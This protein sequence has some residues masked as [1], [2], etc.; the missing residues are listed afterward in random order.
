MMHWFYWKWQNI[1]WGALNA[2]EPLSQSEADNYSN[3]IHQSLLLTALL[4][5]KKKVMKYQ[6]FLLK[7]DQFLFDVRNYILCN[8]YKIKF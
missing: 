7:L 2:D 1:A 5:K 3:H 4:A 8:G 6:C